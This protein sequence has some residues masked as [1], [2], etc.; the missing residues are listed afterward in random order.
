MRVLAMGDGLARGH[1]WMDGG[2]GDLGWAVNPCVG[3]STRESDP[4]ASL[5]PTSRRP[6]GGFY[7]RRHERPI[8]HGN[9]RPRVSWYTPHDSFGEGGGCP[10][11]SSTERH[12]QGSSR[13]SF[14]DATTPFGA[15]IG[16]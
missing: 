1:A 6:R 4:H 11:P 2:R 12:L 7:P 15:T 3:P 13:A 10:P 16:R 14:A 9:V 5:G 8:E